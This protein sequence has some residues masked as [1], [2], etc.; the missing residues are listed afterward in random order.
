MWATV[1]LLLYLKADEVTKHPCQVC[2]KVQGDEVV[3][4]IGGTIPISETY[5]PNLTIKS[6][7]GN[8]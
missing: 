6:S 7:V 4:T 3:C 5:Y 1:I 8:P 2:A